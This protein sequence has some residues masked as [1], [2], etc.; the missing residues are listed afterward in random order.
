MFIIGLPHPMEWRYMIVIT[1]WK[2]YSGTMGREKFLP[3]TKWNGWTV[4]F[5]RLHEPEKS[6]KGFSIG[7]L[8]R[9]SDWKV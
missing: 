3:P 6:Y 8:R 7:L 9:L 1:R 5:L 4:R 2:R